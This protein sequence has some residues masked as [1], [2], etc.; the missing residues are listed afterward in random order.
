MNHIYISSCVPDGGIFHYTF[1]NGVLTQQDFTPLDS[2]MYTIIR[3]G[4][5]HVILRE[6][7]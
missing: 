3:D 2:P 5:L 6:A 4:K 1:E 7:D